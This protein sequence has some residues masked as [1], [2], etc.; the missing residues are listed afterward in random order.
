MKIDITE[1]DIDHREAFGIA[2]NVEFL[3]HAHATM[4]LYGVVSDETT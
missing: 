3:R 2:P 1:Q 4:Q